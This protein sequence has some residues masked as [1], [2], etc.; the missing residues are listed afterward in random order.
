MHMLEFKKLTDF[1]RGTLYNILCDAYSYDDWNKRIWDGNWKETDDFFYDNPEIAEE[2][3]ET[4]S[5]IRYHAK[6]EVRR[7]RSV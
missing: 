5:S 6:E 3:G 4:Y 2:I 7:L 1:P